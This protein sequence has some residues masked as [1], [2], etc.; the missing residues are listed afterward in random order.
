MLGGRAVGAVWLIEPL[1]IGL[2]RQLS[3]GS[4]LPAVSAGAGGSAWES[5]PPRHV[6]RGATGFED[7]GTHRG[8]SAPHAARCYPVTPPASLTA[9]AMIDGP[10]HGPMPGRGGPSGTGQE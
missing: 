2:G 3:A 9:S 8:P 6:E 7:R 4:L 5:N 10:T 1:L